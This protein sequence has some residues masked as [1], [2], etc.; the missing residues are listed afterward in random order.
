MGEHNVEQQVDEKKAQ[1]FMKA[2]LED[3][4]ALAFMLE[5]DRVESDVTRIGAEQ[6]LFL[7]NSAWRPAPAATEVLDKIRDPHFTNEIALFNLAR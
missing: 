3:L 1:A 5:D 6:E 7:V 4:R 2:L